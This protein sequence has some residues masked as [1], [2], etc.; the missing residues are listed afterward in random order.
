MTQYLFIDFSSQRVERGAKNRTS[1][2]KQIFAVCDNTYER[3][4]MSTVQAGTLF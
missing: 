3:V 4:E 2:S 1:E